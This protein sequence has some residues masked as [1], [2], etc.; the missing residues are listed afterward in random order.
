MTDATLDDPVRISA[1]EFA[2]VGTGV[3]VR[4]AIGMA[5]QRHC[6][7]GDGRTFSEPLFQLIIVRLVFG[8]SEPPAI[9][10]DHNA[11]VIRVVEGLG[12]AREGGLVEVPLWRG[13]LPDELRKQAHFILSDCSSDVFDG[14]A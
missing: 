2:D 6:G 8:Q 4:C 11:D 9:I 10:K 7:H 3:R 14:L 13:E 5:F 1:R 12:A